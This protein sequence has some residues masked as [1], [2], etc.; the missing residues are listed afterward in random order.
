MKREPK[1][2]FKSNDEKQMA[3]EEFMGL[4]NHP[5]WKRIIVYYDKKIDWLQKIING[6]IKK[7]DGTDMVQSKED[8]EL[9]R[10]RRNMALQ[11]RNLPDIL[12][13]AIEVSQSRNI[14]FDPYDE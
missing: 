8:L 9:Y 13:E 12:I 10:S 7:D 4:K 5:G 11:F 1:L 2:H 6:D 3:S 14:T